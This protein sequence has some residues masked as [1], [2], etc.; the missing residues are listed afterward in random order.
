MEI[1]FFSFSANESILWKINS[2]FLNP[3]LS[4]TYVLSSP[5]SPIPEIYFEFSSIRL[6]TGSNSFDDAFSGCMPINGNISLLFLP[7]SSVFF[8]L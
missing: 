8:E 6:T 3:I 1:G 5:I 4:E 2:W 7:S